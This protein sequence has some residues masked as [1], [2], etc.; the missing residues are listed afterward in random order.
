MVLYVSARGEAL[1]T[2]SDISLGVAVSLDLRGASFRE[3]PFTSQAS[4]LPSSYLGQ[5]HPPEFDLLDFGPSAHV[6]VHSPYS[7]LNKYIYIYMY[8]IIYNI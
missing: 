8:I 2:T 1:L 5:A 3:L 7:Y 4:S 6:K